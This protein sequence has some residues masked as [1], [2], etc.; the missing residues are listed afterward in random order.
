VREDKAVTVKV[1]RELG[2]EAGQLIRAIERTTGIGETQP[3]RKR[4][5][6]PLVKRLIELT[7]DEARLMGSHYIGTEHFLL[8]LVRLGEGTAVNVLQA[9]GI[10]LD[11]LRAETERASANPTPESYNIRVLIAD[12]HTFIRRG[13][14]ALLETT[15]EIDVVAEASDGVEAIRKAKEFNPDVILLDLMMPTKTGFE[16]I[17]ELR[18]EVPQAR[19][20]VLTSSADD[21]H[22]FA[23]IKAGAQGYLFKE[24]ASAELLQAIQDI[25]HGRP[26]LHPAIA[27]KLIRELNRP[28]TLP[29]SDEPLTE[30]EAEILILIARGLA[31]PDIADK[32]VIH[33]QTVYT[34]ITSILNKLQHPPEQGAK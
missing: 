23:A 26:S 30:R 28:T 10:D 20:L 14:I 32:L 17:P 21:E 2:V 31:I 1:L 9:L 18:R 24:I 8:G 11:R 5:L 25:Y 34:H 12:D 4:S 22:I 3:S 19:I 33:E 13:L 29:P 15:Q 7:V 27:R 16:A 6:T